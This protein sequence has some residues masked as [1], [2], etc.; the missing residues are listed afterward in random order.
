MLRVISDEIL[1]QA[2][3]LVRGHFPPFKLEPRSIRRRAPWPIISARI[4]Q[5]G[6]QPLLMKHMIQRADEIRGGI[7]EGTVEVEATRSLPRS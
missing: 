6:G 3:D 7:D 5:D 2:C 1:G 4:Q